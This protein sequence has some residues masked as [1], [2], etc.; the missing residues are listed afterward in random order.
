MRAPSVLLIQ[1]PMLVYNGVDF[2]AKLLKLAGHYH[3]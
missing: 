1:Q 3:S 2:R